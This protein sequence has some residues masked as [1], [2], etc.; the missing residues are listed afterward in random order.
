LQSLLARRFRPSG[1]RLCHK[2]L[3]HPATEIYDNVIGQGRE[4]INVAINQNGTNYPIPNHA[5]TFER[6]PQ[7]YEHNHFI[8]QYKLRNSQ[9]EKFDNSMETTTTYQD[10]CRFL[11]TNVGPVFGKEIEAEPTL[12]PTLSEP[13]W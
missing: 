8:T 10:E 3:H 7:L 1:Q 11:E 2:L 5:A 6:K 9:V 13:D 4:P 12:A